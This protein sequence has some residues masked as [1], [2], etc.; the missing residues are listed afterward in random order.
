MSF[1][2]LNRGPEPEEMDQAEQV[3]SYSSAAS[4]RHLEAI[5]DTLSSI[6]SACSRRRK[7]FPALHRG[8]WM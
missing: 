3:E 5:D 2:N 8:D 7:K 1:W 4:E 6:C